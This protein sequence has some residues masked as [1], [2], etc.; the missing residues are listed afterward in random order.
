MSDRTRDEYSGHESGEEIVV[1]PIEDAIDLHSF[2]P[3][4][5]LG[6][7]DAYLDAARER[8]LREVRL[9]HGRGKGV[10]RARIQQRLATDARVERFADAPPARGGWGATVVWLRPADPAART[11][12]SPHAGEP[13]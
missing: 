7:V 6:V 5:V 11:N 4:D 8:G 12:A 1:V 10:Q 2:L 9:I 3:R 13:E